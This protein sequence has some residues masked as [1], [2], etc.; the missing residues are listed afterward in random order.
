MVVPYPV[1]FFL[2]N[3]TL[4]IPGNSLWKYAVT[5]ADNNTEMKISSCE[6][7]E[8]LQTI[9]FKSSTGVPLLFKTEIDKSS[10]YLVL[11]DRHN[12][13][14]YVLQIKKDNDAEKALNLNGNSDV[15]HQEK[16]PDAQIAKVLVKTISCFNLS[17]P[18]LSYGINC[19]S[20]KKS[21]CAINDNFLIDELE[22]Y[23]EES[24]SSVNCVQL[25]LYMVQ[26]KS[27]QQC[28]IR[29]QPALNQAA[30]V[31]GS[32]TE[33]ISVYGEFYEQV[34]CLLNTV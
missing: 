30:E 2:D 15:Y 24:T 7:W 28:C 10:S 1:S 22:D 8:T 17:S 14:I 12:R 9:T 26:P 11:S 6:T 21:K 4:P 33:N 23:E 25:D 20:I 16:E 3:H 5:F 34:L 13:Q 32:V 29:Y 31:L 19:A 18:I 27:V